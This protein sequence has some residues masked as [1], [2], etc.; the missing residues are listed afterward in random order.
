MSISQRALRTPTLPTQR[1]AARIRALE[2]SGVKIW[3]LHQG[4]PQFATPEVIYNELSAFRAKT[5]AYPGAAGLP[6]HVQAWKDAYTRQ[7]IDTTSLTVIPTCG[8]AEAIHMALFTVTD[9]GDEVLVFEPVYSGFSVIAAMLGCTFIPIQTRFEAGYALPDRSEWDRRVTDRTKALILINP[10]N[11]TGRVVSQAMVEQAAAF[12]EAH[13]LILIVDE[14]YRDLFMRATTP[15]PSALTLTHGKDRLIL[16]DSLSKRA[17]VPGM[18]LGVF[19]TY[20]EELKK[21]ALKY[22]MSRSGTGRIEQSISI[23]LLTHGDEVIARNHDELC[24]RLEAAV[25]CLK[26]IPDINVFVPHGGMFV[27]IKT[28]GID[29]QELLN[30]FLEE[31]RHEKQTVTFLSLQDFSLTPGQ[32]KEELR[33][34]AVYSPEQLVEAIAVFATGL[35]AYRKTLS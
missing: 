28:P 10:D 29:T 19:V 23:P 24:N 13:N 15:P 12:A 33:L 26:Q 11:P 35:A 21:H 18:R 3:K 20:N 2:Q 1:D 31:F 6:E 27:V 8:A 25:T 30:F 9:P 34:A 7:G 4:D 14:T 22:A 32:G 5:L 16:I 17:G